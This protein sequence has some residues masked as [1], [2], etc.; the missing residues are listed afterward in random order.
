VPFLLDAIDFFGGTEVLA[1][2]GGDR[3][4]LTIS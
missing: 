1:D 4:V 3:V 2:G